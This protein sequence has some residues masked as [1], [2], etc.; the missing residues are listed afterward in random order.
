[1]TRLISF[2]CSH[3]VLHSRINWESGNRKNNSKEEA[4]TRWIWG[5]ENLRILFWCCLS[6]SASHIVSKFGVQRLF[7][8]TATQVQIQQVNLGRC[9]GRH[10]WWLLLKCLSDIRVLETQRKNL[11][12]FKASWGNRKWFTEFAWMATWRLSWV[13]WKLL[14]AR[15]GN[16]GSGMKK[17]FPLRLA[18]CVIARLRWVYNDHTDDCSCKNVE[19]RWI[20]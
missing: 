8:G 18:S 4:L 13:L 6:C 17:C 3:S 12:L 1:M 14:S 19:I 2:C 5:S 20:N 11:T 9:S 16:E 15:K 7:W 10:T